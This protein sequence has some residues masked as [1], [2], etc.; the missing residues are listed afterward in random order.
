[1]LSVSCAIRGRR[2]SGSSRPSKRSVLIWAPDTSEIAGDRGVTAWELIASID[3]GRQDNNLSSTIRLF[4]LRYYRAARVSQ[5][6]EPLDDLTAVISGEFATPEDDF[7][8]KKHYPLFC[9]R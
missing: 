7:G 9:G 8:V 5:T 2:H 3:A 4:V 1:M 6:F